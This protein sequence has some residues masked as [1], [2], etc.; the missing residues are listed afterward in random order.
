LLLG[1]CATPGVAVDRQG[2]FPPPSAGDGFAFADPG[3]ARQPPELL[4]ALQHRMEAAGLVRSATP[5][6]F[7][8]EVAYSEREGRTGAFDA[9]AG[10]EPVWLAEPVRI[11]WWSW[12][13]HP[14]VR[15]LTVRIVDA[16]SGQEIYR[17][18]AAER[19]G[20]KTG[21]WDR[22]AEAAVGGS[23]TP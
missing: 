11:R 8:V 17:A 10:A 18:R 6:R 3:D 9:Q 5:A 16:S 4:G 23:P 2:M 13:R 12:N 7:R 21:G 14:K 20:K 1:G 19:I 15:Q 22:L